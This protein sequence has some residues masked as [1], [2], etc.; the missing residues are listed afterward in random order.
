MKNKHTT[1]TK[2]EALNGKE[3]TLEM[4]AA[5]EKRKP[6]VNKR[7]E[8]LKEMCQKMKDNGALQFRVSLNS[9][10]I[11]WNVDLLVE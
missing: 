2:P 6:T 10:D 7:A 4:E 9:I 1:I 5:D 8:R 3:L 11:A